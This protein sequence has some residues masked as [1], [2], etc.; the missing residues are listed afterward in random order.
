MTS[1]V[2][3]RHKGGHRGKGGAAVTQPQGGTPFRFVQ[4]MGLGAEA[5]S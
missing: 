5:L 2:P 1:L 4:H 3:T